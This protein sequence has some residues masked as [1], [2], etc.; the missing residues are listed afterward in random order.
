[1]IK[2]NNKKNFNL[3]IHRESIVSKAP[4][5]DYTVY[6]QSGIDIYTSTIVTKQRSKKKRMKTRG[7]D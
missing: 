6:T 4:K 5:R 2:F 7:N 1:M 3:I